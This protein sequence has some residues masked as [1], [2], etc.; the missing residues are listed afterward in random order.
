MVRLG[1]NKQV[2]EAHRDSFVKAGY[3]DVEASAPAQ[4]VVAKPLRETAFGRPARYFASAIPHAK[5]LLEFYQSEGV[6]LKVISALQWKCSMFS[7]PEHRY[8]PVIS[9][10]KTSAIGK[11]HDGGSSSLQTQHFDRGEFQVGSFRALTLK[12]ACRSVGV[13]IASKKLPSAG[14]VA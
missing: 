9:K 11:V 2:F 10:W 3:S 8:S 12:A 4:A 7:D 14:R 5:S 6:S 1:P 13:T